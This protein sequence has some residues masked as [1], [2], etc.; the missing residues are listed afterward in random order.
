M[1]LIKEKFDHIIYGGIARKK[2]R[3]IYIVCPTTK[4]FNFDNIPG[5]L[6]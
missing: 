2:C 6:K 4:N 3:S 1:V 5:Q